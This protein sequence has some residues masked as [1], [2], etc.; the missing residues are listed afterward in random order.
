[1]A[2]NNYQLLLKKLDEFTRKYYTNQMIRGSILFLSL[3]VIL[4]LSVAV[5]EFIG[6]FSVGVRTIL[7]YSFSALMLLVFIF[8]I[9]RPLFKVLA[10]GKRISHEQAS[11]II[12]K[13]FGQVNDKLFNVLQLNHQLD[14]QD[15]NLIAA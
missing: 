4:F 12:G 8:F 1:M 3:A 6:E 5:V 2:E 7:F 11:Q 14:S 10:I 15:S 9:V 13:H